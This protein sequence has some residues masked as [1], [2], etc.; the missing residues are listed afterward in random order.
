MNIYSEKSDGKNKTLVFINKAQVKHDDQYSYDKVEYVKAMEKVII[1][2]TLHDDFLQTPSKHLIGNGCPKCSTTKSKATIMRNYGVEHPAQA[3]SVKH[4]MK[5][6]CLDR[7]GVTSPQA[8]PLIRDKSKHTMMSRY[9]VTRPHESSKIRDKIKQTNI[10]KYGV[11]FPLQSSTIRMMTQDTCFE[12]YG[13]MNISQKHI[14]DILIMIND[15]EWLHDQYIIQQ[16]TSVGIGKELGISGTTVLNKL[17]QH[18]VSI[19]N[20]IRFSYR[21]VQW[22]QTLHGNIQHALNGG[23]Y[24]IPGT[25]YR[26]DGYCATTN[27]VYEFHG[28]VWHGNPNV[29]AP[30]ELCNPF[31]E[32]TASELYKNTIT[33]ENYIKSLGYNLVVMWEQDWLILQ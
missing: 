20:S 27:T 26:V 11:E 12:R 25:R 32:L 22:L 17:H 33:R 30:D 23:E 15:A 5:Q 14:A 29:F 18:D 10:E 31:S 1:T 8:S 3:T 6:T 19:K 16:K 9:G 21:C 28:D 24:K 4:K 7:Y 13:V 2:C